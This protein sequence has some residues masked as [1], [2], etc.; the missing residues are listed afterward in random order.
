MYN[1]YHT[2]GFP[3]HVSSFSLKT[4]RPK[5]RRLS[6]F[7]HC[8]CQIYSSLTT[9]MVVK[10]NIIQRNQSKLNYKCRA[11]IL[12][13]LHSL[14][15]PPGGIAIRRVCLLVDMFVCSLVQTL[16]SEFYGSEMS[17]IRHALG[18]KCPVPS[19]FRSVIVIVIGA[20]RRLRSTT[21]FCIV[22]IL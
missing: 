9:N 6:G 13:F 11:A 1:G 15:A 14:L 16:R 21:A 3:A 20:W 19:F 22:F 8:N 17:W 12:F 2:S 4:E 18:P 7:F 5:I 10:Y